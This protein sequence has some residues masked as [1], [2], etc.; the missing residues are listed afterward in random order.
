MSGPPYPPAIP[1]GFNTLGIQTIVPLPSGTIPD[2]DWWRTVLSQYANSPIVTTLI[3][4]MFDCLD[5]T[6]NLD[7]FF[8]NVWNVLTAVGYGLD[9]WG[10][11]VAVNRV[12]HLPSGPKYLGFDEGG[13]TDYDPFN[14][15]PWFS[16]QKLTDNYIMPDDGFR[17][18]VLAKAF[19]NICDGSVKSINKILMTLFGASGKCY[20]TDGHDM[21]MTYTFE[22]TPSPVQIAIVT[23]SGVLPTPTGVSY[24]IVK[25]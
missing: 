16:G 17:V 23:E 15:S 21:T 25:P 19:A 22:F 12:L 18:L 8:K 10:T 13:T 3:E 4:N 9:C 11:I 2:F 6:K 20:C 24:T 14:Q 5:Q 7:D 1:P